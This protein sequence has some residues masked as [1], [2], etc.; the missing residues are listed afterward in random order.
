M[1]MVVTV[2]SG[3]VHLYSVGYMHGDPALFPVFRV[4]GDLFVSRC[5]AWFWLTI[6]LLLYVFWELVGL[7]SYLLIGFWYEKPSAAAACKKSVPGKPR[8]G[9][10]LF[11]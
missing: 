11:S 7:S 2:V 3:L 10:G 9:P 8:R 6:F 4:P 5:W 1:L